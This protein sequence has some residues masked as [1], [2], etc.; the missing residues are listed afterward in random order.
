MGAII[1][2]KWFKSLLAVQV[3]NPKVTHS[4]RQKLAILLENAGKT[5]QF[6]RP[7]F[8]TYDDKPSFNLV[9]GLMQARED[10]WQKN[11]IIGLQKEVHQLKEEVKT[12]KREKQNKRGVALRKL[13][14]ISYR[15]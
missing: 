11:S 7:Q 13:S 8:H 14:G 4:D 9:S 6:C 15:K 5:T 1:N 3:G 2:R 10:I 12:L